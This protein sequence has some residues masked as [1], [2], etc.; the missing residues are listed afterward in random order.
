VIFDLEGSVVSEGKQE[1]QPMHL[2]EPNVA[3]YPGD[4][5]WDALCTAAR[6]AMDGFT[7]KV[8]EIIGIGIGCI[9]CCRVLMKKDGMLAAPVISWM[10]ERVARPYEHIDP[11]VAY[12]ASSSGYLTHRLTGE[13]NDNA[14]NYFGQWPVDYHTWQWSGDGEL[15]RKFQI[16]RGMLFN[17]QMPGTILGHVTEQASAATCFPQG[18]PVAG[19]TA[20]KA[21]EALG[22]GLVNENSAVI[23]LGTYISLIIQGKELPKD[24]RTF[25]AIMSSMPYKY[26]Y[27]SYGIRRGMWTV[28]W[29]R[30]LLGDSLAAKAQAENI[31]PEEYLNREA[32]K[33]PAGCDGL[34][35]VL[36]WLA[37]PW[38]PYKRGVII[39]FGAHMDYAF[40][41]RSI[42]EGIAFTM[43]NNYDAMCKELGRELKEIIITGGGSNS[44]LFMQIFADVFDLPAKRNAVNNT[45]GIGAAINAA[46][47]LGIYSGY[48]EAVGRM[49]RV[50]DTFIPIPENV[51]LYKQLNGDVYRGLTQQTD[52]ILKK[53]YEVLKSGQSGQPAITG[54][55]QQ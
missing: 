30:G 29:F 34:M 8:S 4:D 52:I 16:P 42:L 44:S 40:I 54:W 20:D 19:T 23:S 13:F 22:A 39:G 35:T 2:A 14:G 36:D 6:R 12:V 27:E 28:S 47:A 32:E 43:K 9:R 33:V 18:L 5:L 21:V 41:Y 15:I 49:V 48:E 1:L 31:S 53:S 3:E 37:N 25:W 51:R 55:S 10:D 7:G 45:A 11:G 26:L 46:I 50:R 24:P 17:I 38:E